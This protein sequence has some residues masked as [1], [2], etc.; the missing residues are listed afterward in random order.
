ML[1]TCVQYTIKCNCS[2]LAFAMVYWYSVNVFPHHVSEYAIVRAI[3]HG[4]LFQWC[5]PDSPKP[6]SPKLGFRLKLG[7]GLGFMVKG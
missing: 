6:D 1:L 2:S 4:D 3:P 5:L 7:L